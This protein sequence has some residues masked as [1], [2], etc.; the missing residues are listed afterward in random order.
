V[1]R[2]H[3]PADTSAE[4]PTQL[5]PSILTGLG[6]IGMQ[7][8][9]PV[10]LGALFGGEPLLLIGP[11][12]TGKSFLLA[13]LCQALSL[14]WRHY[15]A[16]MLNFDDL[17]G[18]PLPDGNGG[19]QYI[20]TPSSIWG[21]E[22]VF[23][24]EISRCRPDL[25]NK[26]FP[27]VHERRVQGIALE[28]L[29]YRWSAMNPPPSEDS[30]ESAYLGSEPLDAALADRFAFVIEMPAWERFTEADQES[31]ILSVEAPIAPLWSQRLRGTLN[32]GKSL[33]PAVRGELGRALAT[34]VRLVLGL[35]ARGGLQC[36]PRR[37]GMLLRNIAAVHAAR[38]LLGNSAD[39]G[40]SA[41]LALIN[42][43]PQRAT[44]HS[45]REVQLLAAHR[46][47]WSMLDLESTDPRRLLLAEA[48]PLRRAMR[49]ARFAEL[50]REDL[51][52][53]TAD[54]LADLAPGARH[55][56]AVELFESDTAGRLSAAVA[57]QCAELYA[58][59]A[60]A[61]DVHEAM[62]S[63]G[64]RYATWQAIVEAL[65]RLP[66][67]DPDTVMA[68]NL[69]AALFARGELATTAD[70]DRLLGGWHSARAA[71]AEFRA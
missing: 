34:Y 67:D 9:E 56:L 10:L 2:T 32:D 24:D 19:L 30:D 49:A 28:R 1:A 50:S 35:L 69:T 61:Q 47:A 12:G 55:A 39:L 11:H 48:D 37:A 15:N 22:A 54:C 63:H 66:A 59:V 16:S 41:W 52:R 44:G 57:E 33:V 31:V 27:I 60:V 70:V 45:V 26:L 25:Q 38:I 36:S 18:F 29:V 7:S 40:D 43:M 8:I 5:S 42:S 71:L 20:Q 65:A 46:E 13:R 68:T 64:R 58:T 4:P 21:A 17:V 14:E 23:V 3:A 51:S 62:A 6:V 53:L